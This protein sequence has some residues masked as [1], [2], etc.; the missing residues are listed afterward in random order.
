MASIHLVKRST[1]NIIV[2]EMHSGI[3]IRHSIAKAGSYWTPSWHP[4][5]TTT[6]CTAVPS[7]LHPETSRI[8]AAQM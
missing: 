4:H 2:A 7:G 3:S 5:N 1:L 6:C 8:G